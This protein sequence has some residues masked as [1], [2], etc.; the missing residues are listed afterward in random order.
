MVVIELEPEPVGEET[1]RP[2]SPPPEYVA[3]ADPRRAEEDEEAFEDALT[4]E[5]LREVALTHPTPC[6]FLP[7]PS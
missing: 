2:S 7:L 4:D 5:Q 3:A 6:L 1:T